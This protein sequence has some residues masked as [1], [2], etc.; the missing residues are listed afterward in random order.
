G[1]HVHGLKRSDRALLGRGDAFLERAHFRGE[2]RLVTDGAGG[3]TEQRRHFGT[4]LR[5]PE[6]VVNEQQYVLILLVPEVFG[7]GEAGQG[8]AQ[9][10]AGRF[11]H[12]AVH[13]GNFRRAQVVLLDD[14]RFR[15]FLVEVAAFPSAL[16]DPR[17]HRHTAMEFGDVVDQFLDDD[18][19]AHAGTAKRTDLAALQEGAD[20]INDLYAGEEHLGRRR[21]LHESGWRAV[22]GVVFLRLD[23]PAFVYRLTAHIKDSPHHPFPD[24]HGNRRPGVDDL[25][26][27]FETLG[28]RH[29]HGP[30]PVVGEVLLHFERQLDGLVMNFVF[31]GQRVVDAGQFFREFNVYH[32]T[33]DLNNFAFI[34]FP[35]LVSY[36]LIVT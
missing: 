21:L 34:H 25:V 14:S 31:D 4:S 3:A 1:R 10:S 13:E 8:D 26:T 12:L 18:S 23:R 28:A 15:H 2:G 36:F 32:R 33:D 16:A 19:L 9:A 24:G 7:D 6:D 35:H 27:A 29:G 22:D 17:E 5:E 20:Q 11:I 30:D